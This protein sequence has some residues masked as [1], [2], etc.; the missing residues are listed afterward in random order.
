MVY[1]FCCSAML[2]RAELGHHF[3]LYSDLSGIMVT[4]SVIVPEFLGVIL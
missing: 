3:Q 2:A 1:G 4:G